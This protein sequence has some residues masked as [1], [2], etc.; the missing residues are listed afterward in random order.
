MFLWVGGFDG[1]DG[2]DGWGE[3]VRIFFFFFCSC[4]CFLER[5]SG[6]YWVIW[7]F[8]MWDSVLGIEGGRIHKGEFLR[9]DEMRWNL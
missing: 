2:V 7:L 8:G 4:F 9:W 6:G 1:F 5:G 3:G